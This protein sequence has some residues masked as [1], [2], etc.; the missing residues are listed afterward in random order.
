M[1]NSGHQLED[2]QEEEEEEMEMTED[3]E[4]EEDLIEGGVAV[5]ALEETGEDHQLQAPGQLQDNRQY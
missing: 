3:L 4:E 2:P 5:E 1:S